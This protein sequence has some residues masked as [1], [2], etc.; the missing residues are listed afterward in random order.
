MSGNP[1]ENFINKYAIYVLMSSRRL[2]GT[3]LAGLALLINSTKAQVV[4]HDVDYS[5]SS[6][7]IVRLDI[8]NNGFS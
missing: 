5:N 7:V 8:T 3:V 2:F 1:S 4:Q 6:N